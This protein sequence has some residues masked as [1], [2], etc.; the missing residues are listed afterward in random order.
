M[1]KKEGYFYLHIIETIWCKT[2]KKDRTFNS[3]SYSNE[4][5]KIIV[6]F[7]SQNALS[8]KSENFMPE[9]DW[10]QIK[11]KEKNLIELDSGVVKKYVSGQTEL[12]VKCT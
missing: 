12:E 10:N 2:S 3:V 7:Q 9:I 11:K 5:K 4:P 1:S 6:V 8:K